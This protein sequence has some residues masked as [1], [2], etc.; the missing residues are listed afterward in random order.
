VNLSN[1]CKHSN[2]YAHV[3]VAKAFIGDIPKGYEV[4][5]IDKNRANNHVSNLEIVSHRANVLHGKG[6]KGDYKTVESKCLELIAEGMVSTTEL[7]KALSIS[8][9]SV[10]TILKANNIEPLG[11]VIGRPRTKAE[12]DYYVSLR[13][14]DRPTKEELEELIPNNTFVAL[15]KKYGV[16]DNA[17][18]K[19][20]KSYGLTYKKHTPKSH[21]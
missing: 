3:L 11:I 17:I 6:Y 18:R 7:S 9:G 5:H 14:V 15:G 2:Q 13:K 8:T 19:W 1:N 10:L 20:C 12:I 16:S 21:R 4:N